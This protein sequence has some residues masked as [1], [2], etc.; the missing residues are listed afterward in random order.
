MDAERLLLDHL[1]LIERIVAATAR[2]KR[3]S[4][5]EREELLSAAHYKLVADDYRVLKTF[6]GRSSLKTYL[7]TVVANLSLDLR[8]KEWG[9]WRPS[10]R[11][12]RLGQVAIQFE[13]LTHRD[14]LS[15]EEAKEQF[16]AEMGEKLE[17]LAAKLP[18]RTRRHFE[19]DEVLVR[20]P[21]AEAG[22]EESLLEGERERARREIERALAH[23]ITSLE[24]EDRLIVELH[25][26]NGCTLA[27]IARTL[28]LDTKAIY[29]RFQSI[30]AGIR[31]LLESA[32]HAPEQVAWALEFDSAPA[33]IPEGKRG[34]TR[35]IR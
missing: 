27:D 29:R 11:A 26:E 8:N 34:E 30:L 32:G 21:S 6:S 1:P 14:G 5:D 16:P 17:V 23:A 15:F 12:K 19:G 10:A 13:K 24:G 4:E 28:N 7:T 18:V 22:P 25:L 9:R 2:R 33:G 31:E 35:A 20:H 3:L